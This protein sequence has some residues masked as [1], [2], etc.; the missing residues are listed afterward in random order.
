MKPR[1][2]IHIHRIGGPKDSSLVEAGNRQGYVEGHPFI[3]G[4][5]DG[6]AQSYTK[7]AHTQPDSTRHKQLKCYRSLK[8]GSSPHHAPDQK[9][10][11]SASS[12]VAIPWSTRYSRLSSP[13]HRTLALCAHHPEVRITFSTRC[14]KSETGLWRWAQGIRAQAPGFKD[15]EVHC[16]ASK[17]VSRPTTIQEVHH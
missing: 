1:R 8:G 5:R 11:E 12:I 6:S 4:R 10:R 14:I 13:I 16:E 17:Q 15:V 3:T 9:E 2:Y 7:F